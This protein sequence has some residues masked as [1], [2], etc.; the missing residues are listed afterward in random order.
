MAAP[1]PFTWVN[2]ES[3]TT[4]D[5]SKE[6]TVRWLGEG[7]GEGIGTMAIIATSTD[8]E[9]NTAG[10]TY[11]AAS[12]ASGQFTIPSG[13]LSQLPAGRGQLLLAFWPAQLPGAAV[14]GVDRLVLVSVFVQSAEA[15]IQ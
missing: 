13:L 7:S 15:G 1:A 14:P 8:V 3:V 10:L 9:S 6:V 4:L 5:R 2:R 11:C 12:Y